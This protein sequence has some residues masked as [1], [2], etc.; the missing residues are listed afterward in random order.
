VRPH[1]PHASLLVESMHPIWSAGRANH[2]EARTFARCV[3]SAEAACAAHSRLRSVRTRPLPIC[4]RR[5]PHSLFLPTPPFSFPLC[6]RYSASKL[7]YKRLVGAFWRAHDPTR[8]ASEGQF[9]VAGPSIIWAAGSAETDAATKSKLLLER[10]VP[11]H[12]RGC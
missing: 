1:R 8:T 2:A 7:P 12:P 10:Y 5:R 11:S 3:T 9:G 4:C 6:R